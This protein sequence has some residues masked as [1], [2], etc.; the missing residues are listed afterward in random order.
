MKRWL[1]RSL[2]L[3][4]IL[5]VVLSLPGILD[6]FKPVYYSSHDG[7]GHVIRMDEFYNAFKD[8]QFPVRWSKRLYY[9]YGYPFFN[10]NYPSTY[11]LGL[12]V[13]LAGFSATVAMKSELI[14]MYILST[15]LM[16]LYLR[17]KVSWQYAVV[18]AM[19]Y[20][21]APYRLLNIYVRG[22][23]AESTAF[24]FPPLLLWSAERLADKKQKSIFVS[25][26]VLFFLGIS[27]NIS[28][29]LLFGFFFTYLIFLSL[30]KRSLWPFLRGVVAFSLGLAMSA[31]F[32]VPALT[33]K[34]YTFLDQ[35]IAKDYPDHFVYLYQ[36]VKG[37]WG[38]GGSVKGPNDGLSFNIGWMQLGIVIIGC[39]WLLVWRKL[40]AVKI[41]YQ[42]HFVTL[43]LF[44]VTILVGSIFFMLSISKVFWD[45]VPLLPFVQFPWR[46][47]L[48]SAPTLAVMSAVTLQELS[49]YMR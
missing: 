28:A 12:P 4:I 30:A 2:I 42:D 16:F 9:G 46:F 11:Y 1:T 7:E 34:K 36:L 22:S 23:V 33:E 32:F 37:G 29:L 38:Y 6:L 39:G 45:H 15:V 21:Y 25:S 40:K 31:F 8:G 41:F 35:T 43:F 49:H 14:A 13:M 19:L 18:G 10:F 20:S 48:L 17:R 24:F 5:V 27:H 3:S 44:T 26:L 47:L